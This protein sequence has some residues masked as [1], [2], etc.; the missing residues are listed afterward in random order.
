MT[1]DS[2]NTFIVTV[3]PQSV[4]WKYISYD[5][6]YL[7]I[8]PIHMSLNAR[9]PGFANNKG[10]SAESDQRLCYSLIGEYHIYT[11]CKQ[12]NF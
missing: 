12:K 9:K 2:F 5:Q 7:G 3:T 11:C 10:A 1:L 8:P 6:D 4:L